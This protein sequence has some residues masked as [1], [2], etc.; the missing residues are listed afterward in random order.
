MRF[1][2][3]FHL[4]ADPIVTAALS[5]LDSKLETIMQTLADLQA[6]VAAENTVIGSAITLINGLAAQIA[7]LTPDAAAID[8]LAT[9]VAAKAKALGD[10]ITANTHA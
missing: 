3:Y 1:D 7:A 6:A 4:V 10:A 9:D 2:I 8:A 5:Q